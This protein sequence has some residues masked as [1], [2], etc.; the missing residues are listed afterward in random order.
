MPSKRTGNHLAGSIFTSSHTTV[1]DE[2]RSIAVA[3]AK[4]NQVSKISLGIIKRISNGEPRI[5]F[6]DGE[7]ACLVVKVRGRS[8][9]QELRVYT[10]EKQLV[11]Q[12]LSEQ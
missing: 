4:L 8:S 12:A 6:L 9:I 11:K 3:A 5:S 1:I 7:Q 2:A 10:S